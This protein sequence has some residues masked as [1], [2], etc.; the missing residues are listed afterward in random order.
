MA[1]ALHKKLPIRR[2]L[3][4]IFAAAILVA[5]EAAAFA[6][7]VP[8]VEIPSRLQVFGMY[9]HVWPDF[10]PNGYSSSDNGVTLGADYSTRFMFGR[11]Q[12]ALEVRGNLAT[13]SEV[14][15]RTITP[16]LKVGM[17]RGR[18]QPYADFLVGVGDVIFEKPLIPTYTRNNSVVFSPGIG[19]EVDPSPHLSLLADYQQQFWNISSRPLTKFHPGWLS[20]GVAYRFGLGI[21]VLGR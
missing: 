4:V 8:P 5:A 14:G 12:P 18:L 20:V 11:F 16:G 6:Q 19:L 10:E 3:I 13:G 7:A 9:S 21:F 17:R 15:L 1:S 2:P